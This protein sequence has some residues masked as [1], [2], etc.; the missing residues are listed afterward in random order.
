MRQ[1]LNKTIATFKF[2]VK[3]NI[4]KEQT[5]FHS[6]VV[7]LIYFFFCFFC[8]YLSI[9]INTKVFPHFPVNIPFFSYF[10]ISFSFFQ[11]T[12]IRIHRSFNLCQFIGSSFQFFISFQF[13]LL[14]SSSCWTLFFVTKYHK[15]N[16]RR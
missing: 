14:Y 5:I 7:N 8:R 12:H 10:S 6:F 1:K 13:Y 9:F 11:F 2:N 4:K 16:S 15:K 3:L